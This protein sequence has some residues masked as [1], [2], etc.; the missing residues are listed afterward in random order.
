VVGDGARGTA[1]P[2]RIPKPAGG[3][4]AR[5]GGAAAGAG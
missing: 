4:A 1:E 5:G 3:V 2:V